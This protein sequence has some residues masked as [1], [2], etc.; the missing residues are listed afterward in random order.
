MNHPQA[1][2]ALAITAF[3]AT[4]P[5]WAELTATPLRGDTRLV[6]YQYDADN[7]YLILTKPRSVTHLDFGESFTVMA[8]GDSANFEITQTND[9]RH[10]FIKPKAE[11]IETSLTVVS[12]RGPYQMIVRSTGEGGKWYQR[13]SWQKPVTLMTDVTSEVVAVPAN[14]TAPAAMTTG[15]LIGQRSSQ[16][17]A[18][19][20]GLPPPSTADGVPQVNPKELRMDYQ[21]Q[22]EAPF[23][24]VSVFDNGRLTWVRMPMGLQELP[25]VF[26]V[27]PSGDFQLVNYVAQDDY[28]LVQRVMDQFVLKISKQEVRVQRIQ[29]AKRSNWFSFSSNEKSD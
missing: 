22:G 16:L 19:S 29:E 17:A 10:I 12:P 23:K 21:I 5:A 28:L 4:A 18:A 20:A 3:C 15:A 6:E 13:V 27:D 14:Q 7:T 8:T 24:P 26:A 2:L 11:N 9:R 25:V 1:A